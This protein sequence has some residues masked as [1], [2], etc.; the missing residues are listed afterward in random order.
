MRFAMLHLFENPM[1]QSE[2]AI[3][4]EQLAL[5]RTVQDLGFDAIRMAK[6][7]AKGRVS[8]ALLC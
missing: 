2:H 4:H 5:M 7:V 6:P 8:P 3:V 1:G